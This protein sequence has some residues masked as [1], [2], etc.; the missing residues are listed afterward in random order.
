MVEVDP[1]DALLERARAEFE[2]CGLRL[3]PCLGAIPVAAALI[4]VAARLL[5]AA[6]GHGAAAR[7][8]RG[9]ADQVERAGRRTADTGRAN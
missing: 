4:T 6:G 1:K 7:M 8:L 5:I 2:A 9:T 3:V